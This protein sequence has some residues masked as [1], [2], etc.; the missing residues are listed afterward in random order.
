MKTVSCRDEGLDWVKRELR[1]LY[2][3]AMADAQLLDEAH[4]LPQLLWGAEARPAQDP[5]NQ[6][7]VTH[8]EATTVVVSWAW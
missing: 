7:S 3:G 2:Q 6:N 1:E 5:C 8:C 4:C